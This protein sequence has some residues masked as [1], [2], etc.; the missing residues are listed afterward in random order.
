M[1]YYRL[2]SG[3]YEKMTRIQVICEIQQDN[4]DPIKAI[5]QLHLVQQEWKIFD[6]LV[7][8][9]SMLKGLQAQY[10]DLIAKEGITGVTNVMQQKVDEAKV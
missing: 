3:D 9:V 7:E 4:K 1:K 2:G 5:Y 10:A 6:I 8:G